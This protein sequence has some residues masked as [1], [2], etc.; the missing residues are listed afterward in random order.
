[1]ILTFYKACRLQFQSK[2]PI[3]RSVGSLKHL[4]ACK[5]VSISRPRLLQAP[6]QWKPSYHCPLFFHIFEAGGSH[7]WSIFDSL[8]AQWKEDCGIWWTG[9]GWDWGMAQN[10]CL[11][12]ARRPVRQSVMVYGLGIFKDDSILGGFVLESRRGVLGQLGQKRAK[13]V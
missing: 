12:G 11:V 10:W 4:Y 6:F 2:M 7:F 5:N 13:W 9:R 3:F 8:R 1:M